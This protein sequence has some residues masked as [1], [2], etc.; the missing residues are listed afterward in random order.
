VTK[1]IAVEP[2]CWRKADLVAAVERAG[3][4]VVPVQEATA[5]V[6][7]DPQN[8]QAFPALIHDDLDWVQLPYA[9]I[10][11]F[12]HMLDTDRTWTCGKGVYAEPVAESA[13]AMLLAGFRNIV[14]YAR[15]SSWQGPVGQNLHG[16]NVL[17][18]GGGGI[19]EELLP[20]L[21][22]FRCNVTVLRRSA[23]PVEGAHATRTLD[24]L[25][26]LLP[27]ADAVV[28]ALALTPETQGVIGATEL[29]LMKPTAWVVNVA[30][31][32]HIDTDALVQALQATSIGGAALDVTDP[33]PLPDGHPLWT[34][35][36]CLI[37]P[38]VA[39][40]PE[41]GLLLLAQRV[42]A[43]VERYV[44][45]EPLIGLVDTEAGY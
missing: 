31:G 43:N 10:G 23:D 25:H 45:G 40:T 24:A 30:R 28:L 9:G 8:P 15:A 41:M 26:E 22:P 19:T 34:L 7:A 39:N 42:G 4:T 17:V 44:A 6:W 13:L 2:E 33:E 16:A 35:P 29:N 36:N 14:G 37:T 5:L 38:H 3:A 20:L 32:G 1:Q 27:E 21:A 12:L 18:L 11:P